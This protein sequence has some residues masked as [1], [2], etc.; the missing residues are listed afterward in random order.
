MYI[1]LIE[2]YKERFEKSTKLRTISKKKYC[3]NHEWVKELRKFW[4]KCT[5][6]REKY[7]KRW[8]E[9]KAI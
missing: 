4:G 8:N 2:Q 5:K 6:L 3:W 9:I 7:V 1:Y